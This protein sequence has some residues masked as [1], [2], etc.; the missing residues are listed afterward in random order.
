MKKLFSCPVL[1]ALLCTLAFAQSPTPERVSTEEIRLNVSALDR[2]GNAPAD[3]KTDDVVISEDGRLHQASSVRRTPASVLIALDTGGTIRQK[4]NID[5]TRS[6]ASA[7]VGDLRTG[8]HFAVIQAHDRVE[9]IIG[10]NSDKGQTLTALDNKTGFGRRSSFTLAITA[11]EK[12]FNDAPT[13]N[14]HL[15]LITDGLDTIENDAARTEAIRE[16]SGKAAWSF[17]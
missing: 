13:E 16:N 3:L 2:S 10:W 4:K 5:T 12:I 15:V 8:T 9:P 14:R 11:A 7:L 1:T 17:M 6:V